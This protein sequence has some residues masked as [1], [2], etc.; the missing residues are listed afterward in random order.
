M[1]F[2]TAW[3]PQQKGLIVDGFAGP[4]GWSE[5]IRRHLGLHDVGLE[6]DEAACRTRAAAGHTT[7]RMEEVPDVLM[8]W[9][10]YARHLQGWG[11]ST[12]AGVL[13]AADYGVPQTRRRAIL[14][15]SRVRGVSAP[16]KTHGQNPA[17]DLFG[18]MV[19]P[20]V[21]SG[22][23]MGWRGP[24]VVVSNYGD[25]TT[26]SGRGERSSDE[27]CWTI[28]SKL[29]RMKIV[30]PCDGG[31]TRFSTHDAGVI[32]SFPREYPWQG[33]KTEQDQ[34]VGNAVPPL[35]AAHVASAATGIPV[36]VGLTAAA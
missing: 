20:W 14:I 31:V 11:Y 8:L 18:G 35:L 29:S 21:S 7:I 32:Q 2:A 6:W 36:R 16:G 30:D 12:W 3:A 19:D 25:P 24:R 27:P 34:Q 10:Q 4:G 15:A 22:Q 1:A 5:G 9:R 17:H 28:T 26:A 23:A 13:D 33:S